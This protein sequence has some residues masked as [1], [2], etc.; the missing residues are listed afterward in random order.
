MITRSKHNKESYAREKY[1]YM[2]KVTQN[3]AVPFKVSPK[4]LKVP[5][6]REIIDNETELLILIA[7][8]ALALGYYTNNKILIKFSI[9]FPILLALQGQWTNS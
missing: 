4:C 2:T 3:W 9:T 1:N 5:E 8:L 6:F 7:Q